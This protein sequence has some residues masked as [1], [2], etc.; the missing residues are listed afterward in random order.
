MHE[1][2]PATI[3]DD[4]SVQL[5]FPSK[6]RQPVSGPPPVI[7]LVAM[8]RPK[9]MQRL[10][11]FAAALGVAGVI[12]TAAEKVE[13]TYWD[14]K[15]FRDGAGEGAKPGATADGV[16]ANA[17]GEVVLPGRARVAGQHAER[18]ASEAARAAACTRARRVDGLDGVRRRLAEGVVQGG[19]DAELPW[20]VLQ[21]GGLRR[22]LRDADETWGVAHARRARWSRV[23]AHARGGGKCVTEAVSGDGAVV[24]IGPEGGWTEDEVAIMT[25]EGFQVVAMGERVLRSETAAVVALGLAHEGLRLAAKRREGA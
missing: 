23:V 10:L 25:A 21:R 1:E 4:G 11:G 17:E 9:V 3:L 20:V 12:I 2:A 24:A 7:L 5:E 16:Q 19:V 13:K 14:C 6:G 8:Q 22:V 18:D 15:L